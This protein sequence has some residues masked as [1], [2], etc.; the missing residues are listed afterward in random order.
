MH[1]LVK[2]QMNVKLFPE[3]E[4]FDRPGDPSNTSPPIHL[5]HRKSVKRKHITTTVKAATKKTPQFQC[6]RHQQWCLRCIRTHKR[7]D[8][9]EWLNNLKEAHS[10]APSYRA[11]LCLLT[12]LPVHLKPRKIHD[13]FLNLMKYMI[14]KSRKLTLRERHMVS[15]KPIWKVPIQ[16]RQCTDCSGLLYQ[17]WVR[18]PLADFKQTGCMRLCWW[19]QGV[20]AQKA[21]NAFSARCILC[22]QR[23]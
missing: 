7:M 22:T 23:S 11:C 4:E 3:E 2:E 18:L 20:C 13:V 19:K 9:N 21:Y 8:C 5:R 16:P 17:R 14:S 6:S 10:S 15:H 1:L 12:R